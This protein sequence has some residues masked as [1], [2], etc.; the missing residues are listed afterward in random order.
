MSLI[1]EIKEKSP[2]FLREICRTSDILREEDDYLEI[3]VTKTLMR[4]ISRKSDTAI[5]LFL[6]PL[7]TI[8]KPVLRRVLRRAIGETKGLRGIAFVHIEDMMR[9][10]KEGGAGD[11]LDLPGDIRVIRDYSLL[12]ITTEPPV[13]VGEYELDLRDEAV[14]K[15]TGQVIKTSLDEEGGEQGDGRTSVLLDGDAV[16]FPLH[17]RARKAGDVFYPLGFGKK[18]KLQ[19]LFVDEKVP[20]DKR[21]GVPIVLSGNDIIWVAGYRADERFKVTESTKRFLRLE[22]KRMNK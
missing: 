11:R 18:K 5:E 3:V 4:L 1:K 9:L 14:I 10:I 6:V 8:E 2:A 22:I 17:I 21:D 16:Q 13:A 7:K 19:D 20:R 12:K 15:E